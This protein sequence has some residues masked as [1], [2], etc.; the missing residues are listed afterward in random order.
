MLFLFVY[1]VT[2]CG[3]S[4][5]MTI[6]FISSSL[7]T[8][9]YYFLSYLSVVDL[10]YS[11]VIAPK[12]LSDLLSDKKLITFV[13]CVLQ[14]YFFSS[15]I[16]TELLV[17]TIMAYDRYVAI[18]RPLHYILI[19][20]KKKCL[21][22]VLVTFSM[23]FLHSIAQTISLFSLDFCQSNLIDHFY[24]DIPPLVRLSCSEIRTCT[25]V[26]LFFVCLFTIGSMTTILVS[27]TL[28]ISSILRINSAAGRRKAFS[29]CSS[30]LTCATIFY[31]TIYLNYLPPSSS[32]HRKQEKVFSVLYAVVTPMLNPLIYSLRNQEVKKAI[33]QQVQKGHNE[34]R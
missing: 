2:I 29:T 34:H 9:M 20:T 6:V 18:C 31:G 30:H 4:G 21:R 8:P 33:I 22:L 27:Y 15:M 28:I 17:L 16:G 7:H 32:S 12:M 13:G 14:F 24:C 3:N 5:M 25:I 19:M 11:S 23:G 26:T 1:M 10:F